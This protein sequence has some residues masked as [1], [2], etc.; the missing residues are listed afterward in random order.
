MN[1]LAMP[2]V[3]N[4]MSLDIGD[5]RTGVAMARSDIKLPSPH[6]FITATGDELLHKIT[7]LVE[8]EGC[9]VVVVGIPRGLEGQTT[10][11]TD[12]IQEIIDKLTALLAVPVFM[13]DEALTS[14]KAEEELEARGK[15]YQ[16]GDIDALAA[17]YILQDF[18]AD[19]PTIEDEI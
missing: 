19:H 8:A 10:K 4:I 3:I 12:H 6:S 14:R 2:Q 16:K 11:Q 13:Q 17:T 1:K 15:P 9:N 5:A 18:L 7:E